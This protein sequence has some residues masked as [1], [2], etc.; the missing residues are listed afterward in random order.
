M[1]MIINSKVCILL[2]LLTFMPQ[3]L[4]QEKCEMLLFKNEH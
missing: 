4:N 2:Y 3:L 1:H